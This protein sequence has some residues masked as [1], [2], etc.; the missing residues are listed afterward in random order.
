MLNRRFTS[1]SLALCTLLAI[2]PAAIRADATSDA[3]TAI[4]TAYNKET[5]AMNRKDLKGI[6][7]A[8]SSDYVQIEK[9]GKKS[10]L[11]ELKPQL[12][13]MLATIQ[14]VKA[15]QTISKMT[16][17]GNQAT[18]LAKQHLDATILGPEKK[19]LAL[20]MTGNVED[21]WVKTGKST[22][23]KKQSKVL[24]EKQTLDGKAVGR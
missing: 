16:I 3:K 24:S 8:Y 12:Q 7:A 6:I 15:I 23:L 18:I 1:A 11:T 22:W 4:Q 10:S 17:K 21:I 20:S 2:A 14:N 9:G 19:K 13:A 5:A